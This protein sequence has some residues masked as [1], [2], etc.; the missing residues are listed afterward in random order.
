MSK[1]R[2]RTPRHILDL[3]GTSRAD[4]HPNVEPSALAGIPKC[5]SHLDADEQ[6]IWKEL[7]RV[8]GEAGILTQ[9]DAWLMESFCSAVAEY[10]RAKEA[11]KKFDITAAADETAGAAMKRLHVIKRAANDEAVRSGA[12]LGLTPASRASLHVESGSSKPTGVACRD[13]AA[14]PP[15][16]TAGK[17]GGP[18]R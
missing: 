6:K 1:G 2:K 4:R 12:A 9:A 10:R 7:V 15:P 16:P 14:G 5:P 13:R 18:V 8:M 3:K 17:I 11:F